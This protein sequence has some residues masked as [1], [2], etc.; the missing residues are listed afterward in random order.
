MELKPNDD[1]EK[2]VEFLILL[3]HTPRDW[4]IAFDGAIRRAEDNSRQCPLSAAINVPVNE[5]YKYSD[6]HSR[7]SST[8]MWSIVDAADHFGRYDR[9]L[10]NLIL[11][12]CGLPEEND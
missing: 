5:F 2:L 6:E 7:L 4:Y 1:T 8:L 9:H 12:A 3:R 11:T 10:R